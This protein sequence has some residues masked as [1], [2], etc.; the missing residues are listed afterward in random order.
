MPPKR[1]PVSW[2][3]PIREEVG[4]KTL[5][6]NFL[7]IILFLMPNLRNRNPRIVT[8][9]ILIFFIYLKF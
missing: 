2:R 4:F 9:I 1:R 6:F 3:R 8:S 5:L 7:L